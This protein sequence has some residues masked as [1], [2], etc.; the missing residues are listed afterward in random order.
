MPVSLS[1]CIKTV[2]TYSVRKTLIFEEF[3]T[4]CSVALLRIS[5]N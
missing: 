4:G 5:Y 1:F 2:L 3:P